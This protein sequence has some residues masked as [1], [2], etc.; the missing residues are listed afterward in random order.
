MYQNDQ[1]KTEI[2]VR[3]G[4]FCNRRDEKAQNWIPRQKSGLKIIEKC[5]KYC[6][7]KVYFAEWT[8]EIERS[9]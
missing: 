7:Q 5:M 8:E 4:K 3:K 6:N 2:Q 9:T 1:R